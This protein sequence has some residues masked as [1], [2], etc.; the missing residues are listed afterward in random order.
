MKVSNLH[1]TLPD[2]K[3]TWRKV[4]GETFGIAANEKHKFYYVKDMEP[5]EALFLKIFD[6]RGQGQPKGREGVAIGSAHTAFF[7]EQ[8]PKDAPGRQSIEVRCLV[9]YDD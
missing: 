4:R 8:T 1:G 6:S 9:F 2:R 5:S 7:D 3:L